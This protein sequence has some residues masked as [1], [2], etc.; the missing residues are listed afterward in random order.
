MLYQNKKKPTKQLI[1]EMR[2]GTKF[3]GLH[4]FNKKISKAGRRNVRRFNSE[5]I[6]RAVEDNRGIKLSKE[7]N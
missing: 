7:K 2:D 5:T 1:K 4:Q 6:K 3:Q